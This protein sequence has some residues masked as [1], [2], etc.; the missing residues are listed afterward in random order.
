MKTYDLIIV[1]SGPAGEKAALR[2]ASCHKKI[3]LIEKKPSYGGAATHG[4]LPAKVLKDTAYHLSK[5]T[6]QKLF[7]KDPRIKMP[8]QTFFHRA[9]ELSTLASESVKTRLDRHHV[10]CYQGI[11]TFS[12]K[13]SHHLRILGEKEEVISGKYILLATGSQVAKTAEIPFDGERIHDVSTILQMPYFPA[14]ICIV[15]MGIIGFE[16]ASIF[17]VMG[18]KVFFINASSQFLAHVDRE[19]AHYVLDQLKK[20]NV[21]VLFDC[22]VTSIHKPKNKK[23]LL[24][25][26][27]SNQEIVHADML[28][29]AANRMGNIDDLQLDKIGIKYNHKK[30]IIVDPKTYQT[31]IPHIYAAGDV[32]GPP[33][34][35]N[36]AMDE[37][38]IAVSHMFDLQTSQL[39]ELLSYGIYSMPEI[40]AIG[41]SEEQAIEKGISYGKGYAFYENTPRGNILDARGFLKLIFDQQTLKILGIHIAGP[42]ATEIIHYAVGLVETQKTIKDLVFSA[43]NFPTL[44]QLYKDAAEDALKN[45]APCSK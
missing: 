6:D 19:I 45:I 22:T 38:R 32:I 39:P 5:E 26:A 9:K 18:K 1:G 11:A 36:V 16:Y 43:P 37:G 34:L 30:H 12:E 10:D 31:N 24:S 35:A 42:L 7:G 20:R 33:G 27:L 14:S 40:G 28:L 3:A 25:I 44:H 8:L 23:E 4:G 21:E 13:N 41:L 29:Y 15:G 2:A 17:S